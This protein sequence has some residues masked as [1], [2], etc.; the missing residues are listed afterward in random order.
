MAPY[1]RPDRVAARTETCTKVP[2]RFARPARSYARSAS[3]RARSAF[4]RAVST[5]CSESANSS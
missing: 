2:V 5:S 4:S 1:F 3:P